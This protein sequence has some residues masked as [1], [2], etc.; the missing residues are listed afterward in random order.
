MWLHITAFI[1][2]LFWYSIFLRSESTTHPIHFEIPWANKPWYAAPTALRDTC[3]IKGW[4]GGDIFGSMLEQQTESSPSRQYCEHKGKRRAP[5]AN[6]L[7]GGG[8]NSPWACRTSRNSEGRYTNTH[9]NHYMHAQCMHMHIYLQLMQKYFM[10][11]KITQ[12]LVS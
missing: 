12:H 1:C 9:H 2:P 11:Q 4:S 7:S 5:E 6:P 3:P 8:G 10:K